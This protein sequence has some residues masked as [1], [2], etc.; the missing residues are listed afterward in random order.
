MITQLNQSVAGLLTQIEDTIVQLADDQF[1]LSIPLLGGSSIGEHVRH[2][3]EFYVELLNGYESGVINYDLRTRDH[4]LQTTRSAAVFK[5][6]QLGNQLNLNDKALF[7]KANDHQLNDHVISTYA[8]ELMYNL[9]H[10][11]H[12]MALIRVA[13]CLTSNIS[14]P[15]DFGVAAATIN[16]RKACAQ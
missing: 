8:R 16:Y 11:I 1:C 3:L 4:Q 9:D 5:I 10:T 2:I 12:H 14:L 6:K 15:D 7:I 13:I